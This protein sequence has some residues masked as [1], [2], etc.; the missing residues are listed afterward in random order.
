[1]T[2]SHPRCYANSLGNCSTS[3][4]REHYF[5]RCLLQRMGD[6]FTVQG[7][8][9]QPK[10][11]SEQSLV[12]NCLCQNHNTLLS[13]SDSI[14]CDLFDTIER[15]DLELDPRNPDSI[16]SETKDIDAKLFEKWI[17]KTILAFNEGGLFRDGSQKIKYKIGSHQ[18]YLDVLFNNKKFP[19]N[20]GLSLVMGNNIKLG[21]KIKLDKNHLLITMRMVH[22]G[23]LYGA[24]VLFHGVVFFL[25][26][27]VSSDIRFEPSEE[28]ERSF[29]CP[30]FILQD[31]TQTI[32]KSL[33]FI[34]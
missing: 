13:P 31:Q 34:Y 4:S 10:T 28:I 26:L 32:K 17:L 6:S 29:H 7:I 21:D 19:P 30:G 8:F 22:D 16:I 15:F 11:L 3:I 33:N 20:C 12:V 1:M 14:V 18:H 5:S 2:F 27:K 24:G 25:T 9:D 23:E